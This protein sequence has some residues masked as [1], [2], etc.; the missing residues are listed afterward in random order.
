MS[1]Q[2][3][4]HGIRKAAVLVASLDRKTAEALLARMDPEHAQRVRRAASQIGLVDPQEQEEVLSEFR[5]LGP[6]APEERTPGVE[7]DA[8]LARR[9][10]ASAGGEVP[11]EPRMAPQPA[12]GQPS[13]PSEPPFR[14][15][16]EAELDKLIKI[17]STE[18][19][20]VIA[21]VLSHLP[22]QS[23]GNVLARLAPPAQVDVIRRLVD[24]EETDPETLHEVERG[25]QRRL[26]EQ[27]G[28]QRR[29]VA[30]LSAVTAILH[31]ADS[32]VGRQIL[33]NLGRHDRDLVERLTPGRLDFADLMELDDHTLAV[34][35]AAAD[36]EIVILAMV[37]AP[38]EWLDR[39]L[40]HMTQQDAKAI[41]FRLDHFGPIRL[42]DVDEAHRRLA[43]LARR[44]ALEGRIELPCGREPRR[45]E[46][47]LTTAG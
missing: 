11:G 43:E 46:E 3:F 17:L 6:L 16:R 44:L 7:L 13:T 38:P 24:L 20:Q 34:T 41:R 23:A 15:L 33:D 39:L 21:L 8:S 1:T 22:P 30:G 10:A 47:L 12:S 4:S 26:S 40:S 42:S 27:V 25:L 9:L 29:R 18:R 45:A 19:S 2:P 32:R 35:I 37:G 28:M 31:S 36:P 5:G 14:F